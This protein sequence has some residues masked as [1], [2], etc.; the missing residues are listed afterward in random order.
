MFF[1]LVHFT[2]GILHGEEVTFI[3]DGGDESPK[4]CEALHAGGQRGLRPR[5]LGL[6]QVPDLGS[7]SGEV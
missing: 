5:D 6:C 4:W 1:F 7:P 3:R 2:A